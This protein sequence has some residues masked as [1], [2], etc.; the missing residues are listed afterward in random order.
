MDK[1]TLSRITAFAETKQLCALAET[2]AAGRDLLFLK[3]PEKTLVMLRVRE[4]VKQ[5]LFY[6]GEL[7]ASHCIVE[8]AGVRGAAVQMGDDFAKA[9][10]AAVL[11][12]AHSGGFGEFALVEKELLRI[13]EARQAELAKQAALV[14]E[15]QVR[16]HALE[17]QEI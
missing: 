11:D 2:A 17:D 5:S 9:E 3:K 7:L 10:A 14:K 13:E 15:T 6:L 16:F 12:A 1:K 4:P 8:L